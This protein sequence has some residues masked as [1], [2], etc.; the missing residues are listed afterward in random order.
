[1]APAKR[2]RAPA[3]EKEVDEGPL[4]VQVGSTHLSG[5]ANCR[6]NEQLPGASSRPAAKKSKRKKAVDVTWMRPGIWD[7]IGSDEFV[8]QSCMEA[9]RLRFSA[10]GRYMYGFTKENALLIVDLFRSTKKVLEC[11]EDWKD[12]HAIHFAM[13]NTQTILALSWRDIGHMHS[14]VD[15]HLLRFGPDSSSFSTSFLH[16]QRTRDGYSYAFVEING[17]DVE[18]KTAYL[19]HSMDDAIFNCDYF[20]SAGVVYGVLP[21]DSGGEERLFRCTMDE[22]KW[23]RLPVAS[24]GIK[25]VSPVFIS[26]SGTADGLVTV[27]ENHLSFMKVT[28]FCIWRLTFRLQ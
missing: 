21:D 5:C 28:V 7:P 14:R 22:K 11:P 13:L 3:V 25:E 20:W 16:S 12:R 4:I 26:A 18:V 17:K 23:E 19:N 15:I 2:K 24:Q 8:Y 1:M 10:D 6:E 27:K 9:W